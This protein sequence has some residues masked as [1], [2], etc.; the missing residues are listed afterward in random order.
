MWKEN[1]LCEVGRN[2]NWVFNSRCR[3]ASLY[4]ST[5]I[6]SKNPN[7]KLKTWPKT[8]LRL[9]PICH[10]PPPPTDV[11]VS[12]VEY[13]QNFA[14]LLKSDLNVQPGNPYWRGRISTVN[15][16]VLTSLYQL[17]FVLKIL[18]TFFT[19]WAILKRRS[20][21]LSLPLQ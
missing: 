17:I 4:L 21:A 8:T 6:A 20:T 2:L 11:K 5:R 7:S 1:K 12:G 15:L 10:L 16:F 9:S 19:K 3:C 13:L 14:V 18:L